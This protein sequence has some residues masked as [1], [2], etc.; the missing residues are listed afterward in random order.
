M[1]ALNTA[2]STMPTSLRRPISALVL[3][4]ARYLH[5]F[6][7]LLIVN[8]GGHMDGARR[9][10]QITPPGHTNQPAATGSRRLPRARR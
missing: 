1:A 4:G 2:R 10:R 6:R 8:N 5:A 3:R 7:V 9:G